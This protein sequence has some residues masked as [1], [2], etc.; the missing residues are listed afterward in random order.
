MDFPKEIYALVTLG[1][2]PVL[3]E[4]LRFDEHVSKV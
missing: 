2:I 3:S 4:G 1:G